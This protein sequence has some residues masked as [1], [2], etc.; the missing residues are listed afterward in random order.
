VSFICEPFISSSFSSFSIIKKTYVIKITITT[1][2]GNN[3]TISKLKGAA[4]VSGAAT[5]TIGVMFFYDTDD[6]LLK[7]YGMKVT[8]G[9]AD[10]TIDKLSK[11]A[12]ATIAKITLTS[13]GQFLTGNHDI[14]IF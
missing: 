2:N 1:K 13:S 8:N 9:A 10:T 14:I 4:K 7:M 12:S 5:K 11:L 6:H 3:V